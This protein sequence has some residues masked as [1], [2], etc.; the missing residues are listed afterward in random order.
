VSSSVRL[1]RLANVP[2]ARREIFRYSRARALG[3]A[4]AAVCTAS[5]LAVLRWPNPALAFYLA[6]VLLLGVVILHAFVLARFRSSNW[7]V[8]AD[9]TGLYVQFRSY[10]NYRFPGETPTVAF[11]PY[12]MIRSARLARGTRTIPDGDSPS[13]VTTKPVRL[14]ELEL[15]GDTAP[16]T[17]ALADEQARC[18]PQWRQRGGRSTRYQ[19]HPVR[20]F[21]PTTLQLEWEVVPDPEALLDILRPHSTIQPEADRTQESVAT[22][23]RLSRTEQEARLRELSE[24]GQDLAAI[25]LARQLYGYDL[26]Q[27]KAFVEGLRH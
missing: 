21:S 5:A 13:G 25:S 20:M 6:G 16:L 15:T 3:V 22:L 8:Q 27:A 7:L 18:G 23:K 10:L 4:V 1:L 14:V 11:I 9:D 26:T 17:Q 12:E 24:T 19:H 2:A